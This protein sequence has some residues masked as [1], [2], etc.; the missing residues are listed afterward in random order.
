METAE[1]AQLFKSFVQGLAPEEQEAFDHAV[2]SLDMAAKHP[3]FLRHDRATREQ[4]VRDYLMHEAPSTRSIFEGLAPE[5]S[6]L[7]TYVTQ[8]ILGPPTFEQT[9]GRTLYDIGVPTATAGAAALGAYLT[10]G[11]PVGAGLL[12]SAVYSLAEPLARRFTDLPAPSTTEQL[13]DPLLQGAA[14]GLTQGAF[15]LGTGLARWAL[16]TPARRIT[17]GP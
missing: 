17:L 16:G 2:A 4:Y 6:P 1:T 7:S 10:G 11:N 14:Q 8:Y 13:T 15:N 5:G 9:T 12:S 3:D